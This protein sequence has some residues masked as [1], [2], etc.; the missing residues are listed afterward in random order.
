MLPQIAKELQS[1]YYCK[2]DVALYAD[3]NPHNWGILGVTF[4]VFLSAILLFLNVPFY[5]AKTIMEG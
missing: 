4:I 3:N 5:V 2:R 1:T